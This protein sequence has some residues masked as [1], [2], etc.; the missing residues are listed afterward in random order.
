MSSTIKTDEAY[1]QLTEL[2]DEAKELWTKLRDVQRTVDALEDDRK[3]LI[4]DVTRAEQEAKACY[5]RLED[6]S[7][8]VLA[9]LDDFERG[10]YDLAEIRIKVSDLLDVDRGR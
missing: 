1:E 6:A 4:E 9:L 10:M 5:E 3:A 8:D 2:V 7:Y